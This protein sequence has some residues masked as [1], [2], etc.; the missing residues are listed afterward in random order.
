MKTANRRLFTITLTTVVTQTFW[1][2]GCRQA[3]GNENKL[4]AKQQAS[5]GRGMGRGFP[6]PMRLGG[7]RERREL[8]AG[9]G[10]AKRIWY[11]TY[12]FIQPE[13]ITK[14]ENLHM[15]SRRKIH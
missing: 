1:Y 4:G 6:L 11:I 7:V 15:D 5:R 9:S 13:T 14:I 8:P 12:K 3:R 2:T 10:G